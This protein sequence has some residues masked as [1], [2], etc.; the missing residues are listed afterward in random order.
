MFLNLLYILLQNNR[1]IFDRKCWG[2][3]IDHTSLKMSQ[4]FQ[5]KVKRPQ[6]TDHMFRIPIQVLQ[7]Y[8][9][10]HQICPLLR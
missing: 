7:T 9:Q 8:A 4:C 3:G 2:W 5:R 6:N 1:M 10:K